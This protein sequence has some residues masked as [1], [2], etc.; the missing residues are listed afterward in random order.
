MLP[1]ITILASMPCSYIEPLYEPGR[2]CSD[3]IVWTRER[4]WGAQKLV[5]EM[6]EGKV[7]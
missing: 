4:T 2:G 7:A 6:G 1:M 5:G 3:I